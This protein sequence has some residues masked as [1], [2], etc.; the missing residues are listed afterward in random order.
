LNAE[1]LLSDNPKFPDEDDGFS[2]NQFFFIVEP[3]EAAGGL[4][5]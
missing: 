5:V 1:G 3:P 4:R 2:K